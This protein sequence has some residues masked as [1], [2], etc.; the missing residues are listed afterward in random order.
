MLRRSQLQCFIVCVSGRTGF[1]KYGA[2]ACFGKNTGVIAMAMMD[3][4]PRCV[5][6]CLAPSGLVIQRAVRLCLGALRHS[7]SAAVNSSK[8]ALR[9]LCYAFPITPSTS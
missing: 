8:T 3:E 7:H 5:E 4:G 2:A 9:V 1:R 6:R